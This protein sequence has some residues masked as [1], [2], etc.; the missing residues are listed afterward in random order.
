M[1]QYEGWLEWVSLPPHLRFLPPNATSL[2]MVP[3]SHI[4]VMLANWVL[5][6]MHL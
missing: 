1:Y 2:E 3:N 5:I 4:I 6:V